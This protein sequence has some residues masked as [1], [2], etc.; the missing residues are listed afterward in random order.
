MRVVLAFGRDRHIP[1]SLVNG[2]KGRFALCP[3]PG[4]RPTLVFPLT[5]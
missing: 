5:L 3:F 2:V 4:V 1:W